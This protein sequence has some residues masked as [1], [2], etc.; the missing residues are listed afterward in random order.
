[1]PAFVGPLLKAAP[2]QEISFECRAMEEAATGRLPVHWLQ[3]T[4]RRAYSFVEGAVVKRTRWRPQSVIIFLLYTSLCRL[5]NNVFGVFSY[6][7]EHPTQASLA[8]VQG[9]KLKQA[10]E[11]LR[12]YHPA[13]GTPQA[14]HPN[15]Q[16]ITHSPEKPKSQ[17]PK[18]KLFTHYFVVLP[19]DEF[20]CSSIIGCTCE[21]HEN[22]FTAS[23]LPYEAAYQRWSCA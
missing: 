12:M 2:L 14:S 7:K 21:V 16:S 18:T 5:H 4:I 9:T 20:Y 8:V 3:A 23:V 19:F 13:G 11:V 22:A 6:K 17:K 1:M 10:E 15:T